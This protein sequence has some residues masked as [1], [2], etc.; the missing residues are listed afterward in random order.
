MSAHSNDRSA[1]RLLKLSD[2]VNRI[3]GAL[4]RLSTEPTSVFEGPLGI[5]NITPQEVMRVIRARRLRERYFPDDVFAEPAWDMMLTLLHA[6]L[7]Q[8]R[9]SVSDLTASSGVPATTALR[10]MAN[11]VKKG[12][13]TRHADQF[14]ARRYFVEL[15]P[16]TSAALRRYFAELAESD[17]RVEAAA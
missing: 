3:A 6:E 8:R 7:T 1:E 16:E 17:P 14:D 4:A 10:W 11:L 12:L 9:V 13:F 5:P 15:A 2:E